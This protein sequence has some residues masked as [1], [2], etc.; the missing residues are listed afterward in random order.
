[1]FVGDLGM[2]LSNYSIKFGHA[3]TSKIKILKKMVKYLK[4]KKLEISGE[5]EFGVQKLEDCGAVS[6][7]SSTSALPSQ[8]FSTNSCKSILYCLS[9]YS[10]YC[11]LLIL[12]SP[13]PFFTPL[14]NEHSSSS[15]IF[16]LCLAILRA[17][18]SEMSYFCSLS[19]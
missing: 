4:R 1:M 9:S 19:E 13:F 11:A 3:E 6:S 15:P 17:V 10:S 12:M 7:T 18:S 16:Y 14:L 8:L 5:R 2:N